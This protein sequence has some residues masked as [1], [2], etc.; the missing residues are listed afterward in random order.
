M[1]GSVACSIVLTKCGMF[2]APRGVLWGL[3]LALTGA[4]RQTALGPE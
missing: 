4:L 2:L 3:T 1:R